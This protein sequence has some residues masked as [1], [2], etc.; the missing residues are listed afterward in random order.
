MRH[1]KHRSQLGRTK[2][3]RTAL[4]ANLAAALFRHGRI[5]TTLAKA[6][7]LR[8]FAERII[9]MA[10]EAQ[11]A[12]P[13][14]ALHLRRLAIARVRDND[15]V[16]TLFKERAA[17]FS[18]RPGGYTRIYKLGTRIGDA[19]ETAVI[20]L[21]GAQDTGYTKRSRRASAKA[22]AAPKPDKQAADEATPAATEAAV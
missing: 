4:L 10:R 12:T 16:A 8:P 22:V 7:A 14:R 17:E 6:K 9:T 13:E 20:Q 5:Q 1:R 18:R 21:I 15:A 2:E 11:T 3:H 19:A